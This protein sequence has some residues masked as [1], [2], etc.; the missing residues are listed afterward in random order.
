MKL[1]AVVLLAAC[2][3]AYISVVQGECCRASLTL[4]YYVV[5]GTCADAGGHRGSRG[6]TITICADGKAQVGTYCGR[7]S[8]NI[9]GC[10]CRNGCITGDWLNSF[11]SVNKGRRLIVTD[12]SWN[13]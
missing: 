10:A 11:Y 3:L 4:S 2:S 7:G 5:G 1:I 8:C 12:M 6:C 9:F 13:S